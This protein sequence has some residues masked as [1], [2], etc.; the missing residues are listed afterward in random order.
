MELEAI[1]VGPLSASPPLPRAIALSNV[2]IRKKRL[3]GPPTDA[4]QTFFR[5]AGASCNV[6][7]F[8][9]RGLSPLLGSA[10]DLEIF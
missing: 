3:R 8:A 7:P 4:L 2:A 10:I 6:M 5:E 1:K 9:E